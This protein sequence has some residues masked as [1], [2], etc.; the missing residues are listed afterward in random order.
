MFS[1][2][3]APT[4]SERTRAQLRD[5][6]LRSFRDRGYDATTIRLIAAEAGVSVGTTHYHFASKADLVQELY[7]DVQE[8][9]TDAAR[10]RL[11]VTSDLVERLRIVYAT[12]LDQLG[13]YHDHAAEFVSAALA[14]RSSLNPLS[15]DSA[16]ARGITQSLFAEAVTGAKHAL[17]TDLIAALP[18]ALFLSHL[19]LALFWA[20]DDSDGQRRTRRLLDSALALLRPALP[21][22]RLPLVRKPLV[23]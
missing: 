10:P 17:P 5:I 23:D 18:R 15:A 21:L 6:A 1:F 16:A 20:Y 8:R 3:M 22:V 12:G 14:P 9:H 19:L 11:A 7:L 13:P 4:K 2:P